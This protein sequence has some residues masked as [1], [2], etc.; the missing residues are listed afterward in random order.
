MNHSP[1]YKMLTAPAHHTLP[2]VV[3]AVIVRN[4]GTH[5][6]PEAYLYG[7]TVV[8]GWMVFSELEQAAPAGPSNPC[9][10][11]PRLQSLTIGQSVDCL[12]LVWSGQRTQC[13]T[14]LGVPLVAIVRRRV[15]AGKKRAS[16]DA[17]KLPQWRSYA[18]VRLQGGPNLRL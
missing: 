13:T 6:L 8:S 15:R 3:A 1:T 11:A 18:V 14:A 5:L 10:P 4:N 2:C 12:G 9:H 16:S 7:A 17:T